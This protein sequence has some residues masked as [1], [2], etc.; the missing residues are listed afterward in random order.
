MSSCST[1]LN[2]YH[3][4]YAGPPSRPAA[5]SPRC[6]RRRQCRPHLTRLGQSGRIACGVVRDAQPAVFRQARTS[7]TPIPEWDSAEPDF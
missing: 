6:Q 7:H 5:K 1:Q 4:T 2:A 3:Y